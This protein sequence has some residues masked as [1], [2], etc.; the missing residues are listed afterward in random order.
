MDLKE[1]IQRL[2]ET[3]RRSRN[4]LSTERA[5]QLTLVEP[6]LKA[7]GYNVSDPTEVVP[8]FEASYWE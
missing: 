7:L 2:A 6:F 5:T 4:L 1:D 8:E 3:A